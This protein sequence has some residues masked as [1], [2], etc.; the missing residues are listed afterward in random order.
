M[1]KKW[2]VLGSRGLVG[3]SLVR[4]LRESGETVVGVSRQDIDI[5]DRAKLLN[6]LS[7]ED[8]FYCICAAA[9]VGGI[10][11][12][13]TRPAD[14]LKDNLAIAMNVMESCHEAGVPRLLFLGSSC[15]YPK[16]PEIPIKES[17]LLT[18]PLEASNESYAVAKI[19]GIKLCEAYNKQ[20]GTDFRSVMPTNLYGPGDNF[21]E[22]GSHVIPG[23]IRKFVT[24]KHTEQNV[25]KVW[26]TGS[27]RREFLFVDDLASACISLLKLDKEVLD[28]IVDP[29]FPHLNIGAGQEIS[30]R[31]LA[32][33][34]SQ[35]AGYEG[36]IVFDSS[37][38]DGTPSK[39]LDSSKIKQIGWNPEV[40]LREGLE[41][42]IRWFETNMHIRG[43]NR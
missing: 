22:D 6:L 20:F 15:I 21:D 18:G 25:V 41:I 14:F 29:A 2:V 11:A 27:P 31:D 24:A 16:F 40:S 39:L 10:Y 28:F 8:P 5:T 4:R 32:Y 43:V 3:S 38:P 37:M 7:E 9:K 23:L 26:G 35:L 12:K 1:A 33:L 30:I 42:T 36:Q 19:A 13:S 17:S 34:I